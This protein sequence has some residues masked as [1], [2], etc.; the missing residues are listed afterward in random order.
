MHVALAQLML[1]DAAV[2]AQTEG[3]NILLLLEQMTK[4]LRVTACT[5]PYPTRA[6]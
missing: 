5:H 3:Q 6:L 1:S 2:W 4:E